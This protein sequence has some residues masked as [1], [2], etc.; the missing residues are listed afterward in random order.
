MGFRIEFKGPS[1]V[2]GGSRGPLSPY[3]ARAAPP[4]CLATHAGG[5][6]IIDGGHRIIRAWSG[7]DRT[8]LC[9][10]PAMRIP[11]DIGVSC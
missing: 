8:G 10:H 11:C 2:E 1:T 4:S 9:G 5:I 7:I 6:R 3:R